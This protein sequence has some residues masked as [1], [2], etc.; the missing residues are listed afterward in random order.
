MET[1]FYF[2]GDRALKTLKPSFSRGKSLA[3][4][5]E[6]NPARCKLALHRVSIVASNKACAPFPAFAK[7]I[8]NGAAVDDGE[9]KPGRRESFMGYLPRERERET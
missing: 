5:Y 7:G 1:R 9:A 2:R 8:N 4:A 3:R 6:R